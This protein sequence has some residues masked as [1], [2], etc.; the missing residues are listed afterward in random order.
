MSAA[1][2]YL[3][4]EVRRQRA[5]IERAEETIQRQA[6]T[7]MRLMAELEAARNA[8]AGIRQTI[9]DTLHLKGKRG[10]I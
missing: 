7:I 3:D 10:A 6:A 2:A 5:E 9:A 4:A 1:Q 8:K